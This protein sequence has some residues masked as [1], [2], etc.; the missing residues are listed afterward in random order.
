MI[1]PKL[2]IAQALSTV[3]ASSILRLPS[4]NPPNSSTS[5][6]LTRNTT[7]HLLYAWPRSPHTFQITQ[8]LDFILNDCELRPDASRVET[9]DAIVMIQDQ[10]PAEGALDEAVTNNIRVYAV[11]DG[12]RPLEF[13]FC[14]GGFSPVTRR[15]VLGVLDLLWSLTYSDWVAKLRGQVGR[16]PAEVWGTGLVLLDWRIRNGAVVG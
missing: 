5:P 13:L 2:V 6:T 4:T 15:E 8:T 10:I 11:R 7:K 3:V 14:P 16:R 9:L 1:L 12:D